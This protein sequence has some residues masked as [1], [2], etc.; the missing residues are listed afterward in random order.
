MNLAS[1]NPTVVSAP[2]PVPPV[3]TRAR[4]ALSALAVLARDH[5]RLDQVLVFTQAMN[6]GRLARIAERIET[7][8]GGAELFAAKPRIDRKHVD[9]DALRRLPDGT[10]GREYTR[11]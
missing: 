4:R 10:L 5:T 6:H 3:V 7:T 2:I 8:P 1:A 9:F 11:F